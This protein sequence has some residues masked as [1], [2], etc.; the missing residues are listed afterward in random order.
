MVWSGHSLWA[1]LWTPHVNPVPCPPYGGTSV[2]I[3]WLSQ[4]HLTLRLCDL[5]PGFTPQHISNQTSCPG[6][7]SWTS[8]TSTSSIPLQKIPQY[9]YP[10][11]TPSS[12]F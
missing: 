12:L 6:L 10:P 5:A 7:C 8:I 1:Q 2:L 4:I 11:F 3:W 9:R